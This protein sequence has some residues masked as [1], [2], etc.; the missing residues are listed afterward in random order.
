MA[1]RLLD[2]ILPGDTLGA[3]DEEIRSRTE[4][5]AAVRFA[6]RPCSG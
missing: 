4:D 2:G 3:P 5:L 1:V 6:D